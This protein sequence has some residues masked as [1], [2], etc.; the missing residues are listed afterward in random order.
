[1]LPINFH[2]TF[3]PERRL[4]GALLQYA[5]LGKQGTYQE[6]G[7]ETGIPMGKSTGKVPAV[8]DYARGMGFVELAGDVKGAC[9]KPA[10]TAL[11]RVVYSQDR[12][13][14]QRLTQWIA[15]I[16]LCRSDIGAQAWRSTFADGRRVLGGSFTR[17]QL[18]RYLTGVFGPGNGRTGPLIRTYTDEA[19]LGRAGVLAVSGDSVER[20]KAPLLESYAAAYSAV[21]L[22]L[23]EGHFPSET[24]VTMQDLEERTRWF[25]TCF[26]SQEDVEQVCLLL[27]RKGLVAIDRQMRPWIVEKRATAES[28]WPRIYD[29]IA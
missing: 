13:L 17:E 3:V 12:Y 14:G 16:N 6:I 25:D 24:Q 2:R 4:I 18:E 20:R 9:K 10:L 26:W 27:D 5:A 21:L 29:D 23:M 22:E 7:E 28:A 8:L 19:A 1:M 15:H 11:G